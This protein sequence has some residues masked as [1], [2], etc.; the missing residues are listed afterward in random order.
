MMRTV[1][2]LCLALQVLAAGGPQLQAAD[3]W[4]EVATLTGERLTG[5]LRTWTAER[6][7]V[8]AQTPH[9]IP[10]AE[11]LSIRFPRHSRRIIAGRSVVLMNGD[12]FAAD[13]VRCIEDRL[14][15]AWSQAPLRPALEFPLET[16]AGLLLE[17][18]AVA[19][20]FRETLA[21]VQRAAAGEDTVR[22]I[23]GDQLRGEFQQLEGGL[24]EFHT[25]VGPLK[26]DRTR[27]RWLAL[28]PELGSFPKSAGNRW[29]VFLTDGTR[30]TATSCQP[31]ADLTVQFQL[32]VGGRVIVPWHEI[33]RLQQVTERVVPLS[34]RTPAAVEYQPY[35]SGVQDLVRDRSLRKSPL[36]VRGEEFAFGLGVRSRMAVQYDL[37]PG[38]GWFQTGVAI[39]DASEGAGSVRFRVELDGQVVWSS[40]E[41]TGQSPLVDTGR[42]DLHGARRLSLIADYGERGDVGDLA[43][44]CDPL[45]IRDQ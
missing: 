37:K 28:D 1:L 8:E 6:I 43:D 44:W 34:E 38:D 13:P 11:T 32:P 19:A 30:L 35:L 45:L 12:R 14:T 7:E 16:V 39:D 15:A 17:P 42:I 10:V 18:P 26:L 22:L 4:V 27:V 2:W 20:D 5:R 36:L 3:L 21:D 9:D 29:M 25:A 40:G 31:R 33:V 23:A 41:V 24:L